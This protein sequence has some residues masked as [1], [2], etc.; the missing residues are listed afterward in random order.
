[1]PNHSITAG[2]KRKVNSQREKRG[3][4]PAKG[5]PGD[6]LFHHVDYSPGF[7]QHGELIVGSSFYRYVRQLR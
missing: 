1:M 6:K 3:G 4:V 2:L 5:N 7:H